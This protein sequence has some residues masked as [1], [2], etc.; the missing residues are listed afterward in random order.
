LGV[1]LNGA[2]QKERYSSQF[3]TWDVFIA[4]MRTGEELNRQAGVGEGNDAIEIE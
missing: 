3:G 2:R 4:C 1:A